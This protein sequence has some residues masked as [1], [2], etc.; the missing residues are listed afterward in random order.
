M[1][2]MRSMVRGMLPS[3]CLKLT[4]G[5]V[6]RLQAT[7][8]NHGAELWRTDGTGA[9]TVMVKDVY[10]GKRSGAPVSLTPFGDY[11][12][13]QVCTKLRLHHKQRR[14]SL[15]VACGLVKTR[16]ALIMGLTLYEHVPALTPHLSA[17]L[18]ASDSPAMHCQCQQH[19]ALT[20]VLPWPI[21]PLPL[22]DK[23][24]NGLDTEWM[25][26]PDHRD[27]CEGFRQSSFNSAVFFAVSEVN[28]ERFWRKYN[29]S[30]FSHEKQCTP[31]H[32]AFCGRM[33][34]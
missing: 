30:S 17:V 13:F 19:N 1:R 29:I 25:L 31:R 7:D 22:L 23:Q 15:K 12:Y 9:G 3:I 8:S 20:L 32:G 21:P 6:R 14:R 4:N 2:L 16:N 11:I 26:P 34:A 18:A 33:G 5:L 27:L 24:A 28:T 10:P